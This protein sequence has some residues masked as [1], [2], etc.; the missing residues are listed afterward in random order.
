MWSV[1]VII[2][3]LFC[4]ACQSTQSGKVHFVSN[5]FYNFL[6]WEPAVFPGETVTYT[7]KYKSD[8]DEKPHVKEACRN[9]SVLLCD[10]T[11]ETKAFPD[12]HYFAE[13]FANNHSHGCTKHRF[14]P[15]AD[16][17]LGPANLSIHTTASAL[18][19]DVTLPLGPDGVS[20][21]DIIK[22][23]TVGP[24]KIDVV[25]KLNITTPEGNSTNHE[26]T[27]GRFVIPLKKRPAQYCV[28]VKY[29][30]ESELNQWS[31]KTSFCAT[32]QDPPLTLW[33][34][35]LGAAGL[36]VAIVITSIGLMCNYVK[37]GKEKSFLD[38]WATSSG[39]PHRVLP[40]YDKND[41]ISTM[42][43]CPTSDK[44]HYVKIQVQRTVAS[45]GVGGYSPQDIPGESW[46]S[47]AE[48]SVNTG[49]QILAPNPIDMSNQSSGSYTVV[50]HVP[51]EEHEEAEEH[52]HQTT[53]N[54]MPSSSGENWHQVRTNPS[55]TSHGAASLSVS[56]NCGSYPETQL[57]LDTTRDCN[58]Q[59]VL[60]LLLSQIQTTTD[61]TQKKLTL[62]DLRDSYKQGPSLASVQSFDTSE[63]SDSGCEDSTQNTPTQPYCNTNYAPSQP[64]ALEDQQG[65]GDIK[66]GE[67]LSES[68]YKQNWMPSVLPGSE[69]RGTGYFWGWTGHK[70][71]SECE[72]KVNR[73]EERLRDSLLGGWGLQIQ[74]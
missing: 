48:S 46:E 71:G 39:T 63:W 15:I 66:S 25:Y 74:E 38:K 42:A 56:N 32:L 52:F 44:T 73:E 40:V 70:M 27:T 57:L 1:K 62:T 4:Y 18:H 68:G 30:P 23:N 35:F 65:C 33:P 60:P 13:V 31:N 5:N 50:V 17:T 6:H 3:L 49:S 21:A 45:G 7:V 16:T 2:L 12:V 29:R 14:K 69:C 37:A 67:A 58:G 59:L 61:E 64:V 20:I 9:I 72:E 11:A 24:S 41:I 34:W 22:N 43:F 47:S 36:L 8:N 19:V 54:L 26:S 28:Y 53:D 55:V 10:L 51:A